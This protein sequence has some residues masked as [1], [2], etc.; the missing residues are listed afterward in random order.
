MATSARA[1]FAG[2]SDSIFIAW[3]TRFCLH[4]LVSLSRSDWINGLYRKETE[5]L[6][7]DYLENDVVG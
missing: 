4:K 7:A 5:N 3:D 2:R 6:R 1:F